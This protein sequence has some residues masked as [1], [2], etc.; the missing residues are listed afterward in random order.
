MRADTPAPDVPRALPASRRLPWQAAPLAGAI[1]IRGLT[2]AALNPTLSLFL[3]DAVRAAPFLVGLFFTARAAAGIVG[4]LVT[5][6]ISDRMRDR[7]VLIAFTCVTS[8]ASTLCLAV[9]RDYAVVLI[10]CVLFA[11]IGQGGMGQLFAYAK[12]FS[13]ARSGDAT[14][15]TS[16]MRS[17]F[18]AAYAVGPPIALFMLARYGFRPLYLI[19]TGLFLASAPL[20]RWGLRRTVPAVPAAAV[21]AEAVPAEA[22][23]AEAVPAEAVRAAA[24]MPPGREAPRGRERR[25]RARGGLRGILRVTPLPGRLW[26]LLGVVLVLGIVNQMYSIDIALHVTRDLHRSAQLVGWMLG[27]TAAVE[28]PAMIIAGRV[29]GRLGRGKLVGMAAIAAVASYC[30]LPLAASPAEL[31]ALSALIGTWQ[32]VTLSIPMIMVQDEA[33]GGAG[34]STSLY[35]AAFG[36]AA[37][38]AGAITGLTAS[39]VGY[40]NVLWVC[41]GLSAVAVA[42]MLARHGLSPARPP[43]VGSR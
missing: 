40:G 43:A 38:L 27:L 18:S 9:F 29:A 36:S 15:F 34:T 11:S 19:I 32:G 5:G 37:M 42:L 22:V 13:S 41:A 23:P 16:T 6:V 10:T 7:R 28:I 4:N 14:A 12:E 2:T 17:V 8:A 24:T 1:A 35:N 25:A 31:L 39:A 20:G 3:A 33:P 30:L 26:L 21:P